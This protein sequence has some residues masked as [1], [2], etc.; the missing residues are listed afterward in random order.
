MKLRILLLLISVALFSCGDSPVDI[1]PPTDDF[2]LTISV[3]DSEDNPVSN[4]KVS[5][6]NKLPYDN[7]LIPKIQK[8]ESTKSGTTTFLFAL[9]GKSYVNLFAFDLENTLYDSI[10]SRELSPGNYRALW[11]N[12]E[13]N[14]VY[15]VVF[16]V[17][18]DSLA[19][20]LD[21]RDSVYAVNHS[22]NPQ[23]AAIG[24]TDISG[25]FETKSKLL[26][27]YLY[28]LPEFNRTTDNSPEI[29]GTFTFLDTIIIALQDTA[30]NKVQYFDYLL[31]VGENKIS[32]NWNSTL[33]KKYQPSNKIYKTNTTSL[34]DSIDPIG[35]PMKNDFRQNYPNPFDWY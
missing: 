5:A 3:K 10:I 15:K 35:I 30:N 26:F 9:K 11:Q 31:K 18:S 14:R 23:V 29:I 32:L 4:L 28:D 1:Q 24:Q 17:M 27:P 2:S 22:I 19:D 16:E 12:S 25:K 34:L 13:P 6:W 7:Y 20:S 33:A 8:T 21:Y